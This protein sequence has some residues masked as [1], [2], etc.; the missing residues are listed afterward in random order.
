MALLGLRVSIGPGIGKSPRNEV[1]AEA[2]KIMM[3]DGHYWTEREG[4][5]TL[6]LHPSRTPIPFRSCVLK[7]T[8]FLFFIHFLFIGAPLPASPFLFSTLFDG[9]KTASKFDLEFLSRFISAN[10]LVLIKKIAEVPL[11]TPLY[12]RTSEDCVEYQYLVNIPDFDPSMISMRRSEDEHQ[13]VCSSVIS[14]LTLGIVDITHVP[15]FIALTDGFNIT[16][17]GFGRQDRPHH[18]LE[19]SSTRYILWFATPCRELV[20][21]AFDRR[22]KHPKDIIPNIQFTQ[23]LISNND[24][25]A[26][27]VLRAELFLSV[28]TGSTLLP[29]K[30]SWIIKVRTVR[31]QRAARFTPASEPILF[32][33]G[34]H[35]TFPAVYGA[36]TAD[37]VRMVCPRESG[38]YIEGRDGRG[39]EGK[40]SAEERAGS[41]SDHG[42]GSS[43]VNKEAVNTQE[44]GS[45]KKFA[46]CS[47][48]SNSQALFH[49]LPMAIRC[50]KNAKKPVLKKTIYVHEDS[51]LNNL[52]NTFFRALDRH[53][54]DDALTFSWF[55]HTGA[56]SS[57]TIDIP[58]MT[59]S[60]PKTPFKDMSLTCE[61]DYKT[62]IKEVKKLKKPDPDPVKMC[63]AE[64]KHPGGE[65]D[66]DESSDDEQPRRKKGKTYEPSAEEVEKTEFIVKLQARWKCND[67]RCKRFL[68]FP[69]KTTAKHAHLTHLH[70]QSW[71]AAA[72]AKHANADGSTVDVDNPPDDK[73]FEFQET[74]NEED[75]QIL[76]TR[77]AQKATMKDSN[78]TINLTLPDPALPLQPHQQQRINAPAPLPRR[79]P[80]QISLCRSI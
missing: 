18:S 72:Q 79:I 11:D 43:T 48:L 40:R 56:Y 35:G 5:Q 71:T 49:T 17:D 55:P 75:Q 76:R 63:T 31:G 66:D 25:S 44:P 14:F 78:I 52:L 50:E 23:A 77:A 27:L 2:I 69:D 29:I 45:T 62:L 3:A 9:R 39:L 30:P 28:L 59:Y 68:C 36:R 7:A 33:Q 61:S 54:G 47:L 32:P 73:L 74:E 60:I 6:R 42:L 26:N 16:I 20:L 12:V 13:G 51:E 58:N 10:S 19:A 70:L 1:V 57:P 15:D 80:P 65:D 46:D 38:Y 22:I 24:N 21:A 67:R 41:L 64:L 4:Y 34:R 37:G 53:E 8:G